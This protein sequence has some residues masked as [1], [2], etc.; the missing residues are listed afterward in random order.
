MWAKRVAR[1]TGW[2]ALGEIVVK[3]TLLLSGIMVAR[4]LGPGA[5]G[6]FTVSYGF[7]LILT[8]FMAAGQVEVLI[9]E[10]ARAPDAARSLH[11]EAFAWQRSFHLAMIILTAVGILVIAHGALRWTL[12]AFLPYAWARARL[13]TAA[14]VFRGLERMD[15]DVGSRAIEKLIG[16]VTV[17]VV[18]AAGGEIWIVGIGLTL[19]ALLGNLWMARSLARLPVAEVVNIPR[20]SEL[21][22]EGVVFLGLSTSFQI[23]T[24]GDG[25]VLAALGIASATI[26]QYG[27][28]LTPVL[29]VLALPQILA[30]AI[31]PALS[32]AAAAGK[33]A[34]KWALGAAGIGGAIG[35]LAAILLVAARQPVIGLLFGAD[36]SAA[37]LV[38]ARAAWLLPGACA[39]MLAGIVLASWRRQ[40]RGLWI[41]SITALAT[42]V[43][44]VLV[45]P[46]AGILGA[47]TV[48]VAA[49]SAE[50]ALA[51]VAGLLISGDRA[52]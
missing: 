3:T 41:V 49:H 22:K 34:W 7:A 46:T 21:R 26:G 24:R 38:L 15:I 14:A 19:G 44:D 45:V 48:A 4:W 47:A 30:I 37:E 17:V 16:L 32:Q 9:R 28:A 31:Y 27:A 11:R 20:Q 2:L 18:G 35:V 5:M 39:A 40:R 52:L 23:L 29:A 42:I 33:K 51:V 43:A 6:L 10:V 36:F 50:A 1:N 8:Q 13:I 12:M 25:L